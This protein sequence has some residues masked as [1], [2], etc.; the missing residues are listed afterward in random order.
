ME[1]APGGR[2]PAAFLAYAAWLA[3]LYAWY[4]H[5]RP[6]LFMLAGGLLSLIV[7]VVAFLSQNLLGGDAGGFLLIGLVVIAMSAGG[8]MWLKSAARAQRA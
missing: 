4:R 6:D 7:A 5:V 2:T 8:A 3:G 1:G